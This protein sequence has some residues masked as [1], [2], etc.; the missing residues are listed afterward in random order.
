MPGHTAA[1]ATMRSVAWRLLS[2]TTAGFEGSSTVCRAP[3]EAEG[4][5]ADPSFTL[6]A[7]DSSYLTVG[8]LPAWWLSALPMYWR[9]SVSGYQ[10]PAIRRPFRYVATGANTLRMRPISP[11][12]IRQFVWTYVSVYWMRDTG[13]AIRRAVFRIRDPYIASGSIGGA[14]PFLPACFGLSCVEYEDWRGKWRW[15]CMRRPGLV[16]TH[17]TSLPRS[18]LPPTITSCYCTVAC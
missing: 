16:R 17:C 14:F 13:P 15:T 7:T 10:F 11:R 6:A 4:S 1:G 18:L 5:E 9:V 12:E 2:V 3:S 8:S